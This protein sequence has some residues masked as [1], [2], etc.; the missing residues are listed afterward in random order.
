MNDVVAKHQHV[1][2]LDWFLTGVAF[3]S[4]MRVNLYPPSSDL[5]DEFLFLSSAFAGISIAISK[6]PKSK[7]IFMVNF[8]SVK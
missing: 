5:D 2:V 8:I 6:S 1:P 7:R 4:T 3:S